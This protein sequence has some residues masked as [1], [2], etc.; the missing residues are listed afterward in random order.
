MDPRREVPPLASA[1]TRV[2]DLQIFA[3]VSS[4]PAPPG[5]PTVVLVHGVIAS[6]RYMVPTALRLV[7]SCRVLV[8]DLPGYGKST[9]PR[10]ALSVPEL[11]D[12]LAAWLPAAGL[13]RAIFAGNSFGCQVVADLTVRYPH[14]VE[15]TVLIGPTVD[16]AGRTMV[17]QG[18]RLL[19]DVPGERPSLWPVLAS[20]LVAMGPVRAFRE[21][22]WML[23]D[24]IEEK[25][26]LVR[27][28]TLIVRGSRDPIAPQRWV[29]TMRDL[30]PEGQ[31]VM[32]P[33]A[34]HAANYSAP[35]QLV[36]T[37][38]PF[39]ASV[40]RG[41]AGIMSRHARPPETPERSG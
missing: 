15:G 8:P 18:L 24:P 36:E 28:P 34:P 38:V 37:I 7:R 40:H 23:R 1:W 16:P 25:L 9:K 6:S 10:R 27:V 14:L 22:Q 4:G 29:E 41:E 21:V 11:T 33:H 30:L 5:N 2:N 17:Q 20:D 31:L 13:E 26:P 12:V 32:M 39:I 35:G 19:R 3:R